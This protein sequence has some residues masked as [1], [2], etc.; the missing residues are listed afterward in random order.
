MINFKKSDHAQAEGKAS[1]HADCHGSIKVFPLDSCIGRFRGSI[2]VLASTRTACLAVACRSESPVVIG[3][4]G[5]SGKGSSFLSCSS[6]RES[7][8]RSS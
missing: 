7:E 5:P 2:E 1:G 4:G 6:V 3:E 8:E